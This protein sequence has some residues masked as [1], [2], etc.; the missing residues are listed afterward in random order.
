MECFVERADRLFSNRSF[1]ACH[2]LGTKPSC[3]GAEVALGKTNKGN[4]HLKS[5]VFCL[6]CPMATFALHWAWWFRGWRASFKGSV[7]FYS[8]N[9]KVAR[10]T[11]WVSLLVTS[12]F[13]FLT[14]EMIN[15]TF[16]FLSQTNKIYRKMDSLFFSPVFRARGGMRANFIL[17]FFNF[18][19]KLEVQPLFFGVCLAGI[20]S[21]TEQPIYVSKLHIHSSLL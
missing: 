21:S 17:V 2:S 6:P 3:W 16:T 20:K 4:Y 15:C 5:W 9:W 13:A 7:P 18:Q 19:C 11:S 14:F 12:I 10:V 8:L 1:V